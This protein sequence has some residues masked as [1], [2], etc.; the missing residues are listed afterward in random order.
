MTKKPSSH[1]GRWFFSLGINFLPIS[2]L[3]RKLMEAILFYYKQLNSIVGDFL[4]AI[5]TPP[6]H[7]YF[8]NAF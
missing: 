2:N 1:L 8:I 3:A 5:K 6:L 7:N 4:D